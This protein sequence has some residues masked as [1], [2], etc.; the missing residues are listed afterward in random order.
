MRCA[1]T[2]AGQI[3]KIINFCGHLGRQETYSVGHAGWVQV[4]VFRDVNP[5]VLLMIGRILIKRQ[6]TDESCLLFN[7]TKSL[8]SSSLP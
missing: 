3:L 5:T 7:P 6:L 2:T 1:H 4:R 8:C